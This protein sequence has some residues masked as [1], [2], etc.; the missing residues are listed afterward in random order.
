MNMDYKK[1]GRD[2]LAETNTKLNMVYL[3]KRFH[4]PS[5]TEPRDCYQ[6]TLQNARGHYS[7]TYGDS[8]ANTEQNARGHYSF[9]FGDSI[10]NTEE[11]RNL[12]TRRNPSAYSILACLTKSEP[13]ASVDDFASDYGYTKPSEAIRAHTAVLEEWAGIQRLF[14]PEQI[15]KLAE[16]Q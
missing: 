15:E 5:D 14:T 2:F 12:A 16:I 6:V 9:T 7:F 4:F 11:N 1:Q 8:I 3:G 13:E 10:A